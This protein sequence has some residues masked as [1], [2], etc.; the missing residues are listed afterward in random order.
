MADVLESLLEKGNHKFGFGLF[1]A[2][3]CSDDRE[4][5]DLRKNFM[6]AGQGAVRISDGRR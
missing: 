2:D 1:I 5:R 4:E 6:F 3:C